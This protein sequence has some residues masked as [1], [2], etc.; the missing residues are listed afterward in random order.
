VLSYAAALGLNVLVARQLGAAGFGAWVVAFSVAQT[1]AA[2]GLVGA[3][4]IILR[5]GSYYHSV[6][7]VAR[8]RRTIQLALIMTSTASLL[9]GAVTLV[10]AP[11]IARV[12]F[13]SPAMGP[14]LRLAGVLVPVMA[15]G[16]IMLFGTQAFK[17]MRDVATIRN[18]LAPLAR[19]A[20]VGLA[21]AAI[22]STYSAFVGLVAAEVG[23]SVAATIA[24]QRRISILGPTEPIE[25]RGLIR[26]ALPVWG[27]RLSEVSRTQLFPIF[28]GSLTSL[29]ASAVFVAAKRLAQIP[30]S[31]INSM[32]QVYSPMASALYLQGN[33]QE[34]RTLFTSIAKWSFTLGLPIFLLLAI[35]PAEIMSLFGQE[36]RTGA[37]ALVL[38]AVGMLFQFGTGPVTVTLVVIGR[39]RLALI[40]YL[41]VIATEVGLALWLIP[42]YGVV[43]AAIAAVAG[44]AI[45]NVVPLIQV[46]RA[47]RLQPYQRD[48]WKPICAG[49]A[50][51]L[52][53][54]LAVTAMAIEGVLEPVIAGCVVAVVYVGLLLVFGVSEQDQAAIQALVRRRGRTDTGGSAAQATADPP[55]EAPTERTR[56]A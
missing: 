23:V 40:D 15:M 18:I 48:Y 27:N 6:A 2:L 36:F 25:H 43:G 46:Y 17:Q 26:F 52:L 38:L 42:R 19:L 1:L 29:E 55:T 44:K 14:L 12:F 30:G 51:A 49:I 28:L 37:T 21:L 22:G 47:E 4:W 32:N 11:V 34:L 50:A 5:Q 41:A 13:D 3:D 53:A 7:D 45:N 8:L 54:K 10:L 20:F 35:F 31:V 9:L 16:Q 33:R 24:L 56:R 39:P